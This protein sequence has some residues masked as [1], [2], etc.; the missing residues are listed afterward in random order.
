VVLKATED[1]DP[2][3]DFKF[4]NK[5]STLCHLNVAMHCVW[6][7]AIYF[8]DDVSINLERISN[9]FVSKNIKIKNHESAEDTLISLIDMCFPTNIK[10]ETLSVSN[11]MSYTTDEIFNEDLTYKADD[12]NL[13]W[14][15]PANVKVL[16]SS[17]ATFKYPRMVFEN[18]RLSGSFYVIIYIC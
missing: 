10:N 14:Y 2:L 9:M 18:Y 8:G 3:Q 5:T 13:F 15:Q 17:Q 1:I 6:H 12:V 4:N 11:V 7:I 16:I